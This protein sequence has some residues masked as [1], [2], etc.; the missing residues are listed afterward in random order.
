MSYPAFYLVGEHL[1][2]DPSALNI[3][4]NESYIS[5]GLLVPAPAPAS[6]V[7]GGGSAS[8]GG[9]GSP[10]IHEQGMSQ[11]FVGNYT[12]EFSVEL[13]DISNEVVQEGMI[14]ALRKKLASLD[15]Y[16]QKLQETHATSLSAV[17]NDLAQAQKLARQY[18]ATV[19]ALEER[20]IREE[21]RAELLKR[22]LP[23][24]AGAPQ[25]ASGADVIVGL[26]AILAVEV[27]IPEKFAA[28][29]GA[30]RLAAVGTAF[31]AVSS[32]MQA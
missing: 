27:F 24:L 11:V 18:R 12:E 29:K 31:R 4:T 22:F 7:M 14:R 13:P 6:S 23:R 2:Y 15:G 30:A 1:T 3:S 9:G 25:K 19:A 10:T 26:A 20:A 17:S 28:V 8:V 21:V 32:W 5:Y 16:I